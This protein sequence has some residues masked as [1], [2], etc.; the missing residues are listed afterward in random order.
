MRL[1]YRLLIS[2]VL[3]T[4]LPIGSAELE[5]RVYDLEVAVEHELRV[6]PK[7]GMLEVFEEVGFMK[8]AGRVERKIDESN[9]KTDLSNERIQESNTLLA[10]NNSLM[11]RI[12]DENDKQ[13]VRDDEQDEKIIKNTEKII[14]NASSTTGVLVVLSL[15]FVVIS[16]IFGLA[17][18]AYKTANNV[19]SQQDKPKIKIYHPNEWKD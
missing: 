12:I 2:I 16:I 8:L 11:R 1:I 9:K 13:E 4:P 10:E 17:L 7:Q 19:K 15:I 6:S 14:E 5:N 18:T 3:G